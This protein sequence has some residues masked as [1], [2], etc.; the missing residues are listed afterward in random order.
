MTVN[1]IARYGQHDYRQYL[2]LGLKGSFVFI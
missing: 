2:N 1:L